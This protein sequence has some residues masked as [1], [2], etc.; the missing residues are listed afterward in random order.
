MSDKP[1]KKFKVWPEPSKIGQPYGPTPKQAELFIDELPIEKRPHLHP[2]DICL[3]IGGA[4]CLGKNTPV[5]MFD[6]SVKKVQDVKIGDLLIGPDSQPRKVEQLFRGFDNMYRIVPNKGESFVCNSSHILSLKTAGMTIKSKRIPGG[7]RKTYSTGDL[8]EISLEEY[9][10][11]SKTWKHCHKLWRTGVEFPPKKVSLDPY[12]LGLWLGDGG[13]TAP[14]V[15]NIDYEVINWLETFAK[16]QG[17][18]CTH[19][20]KSINHYIGTGARGRKNGKFPNN[21]ILNSLR[22]YDLINNKHI[23]EDYLRN[24]RTSRLLLLAGLIDSDGSVNSESGLRIAL[25]SE[26]LSNDVV[27]LARSLGFSTTIR[28]VRRERN[29]P[30]FQPIYQIFISGSVDEVPI[31]ISRKVPRE[32]T[33]VV[34]ACVTGF[35]VEDIGIGE[36]YGFELSGDRLFLLGDFTVT[37]NS[38]KTTASCARVISYLLKHPKST[39]IIGAMNFPILQRTMLKEFGERFGEV[40][41]WDMVGKPQSPILRKPTQTQKEVTLRNGSRALFIHFNDPLILRGISA[42]LIA[43][44]EASLLPDEESFEELCRRLSGNKGP[45]RQ[46][47]LTT[48]PTPRGGWI[49]D[50]FK[51]HQLAPNYEGVIEPI[52]P[53]CSCHKCQTCLNSKSGN[54]EFSDGVCPNCGNIKENECPGNQVYMRV[55]TTSAW[56][57]QHLPDDYVQT[58]KA[59]M[60]E[61]TYNIFIEGSI[62][63]I[64]DGFVYKGFGEENVYKDNEPIS[65]E[66][67]LI[68]TLD[69]NFEPQCSMICQ[70][71]ETSNGFCI[72]V[73]DEIVMWNALPEHAAEQFCAHP[74]VQAWKQAG[75]AVLIYGDP[76]GLF[77]TGDNLCASFYQIIY[78]VL[79]RN[80]FDAR[81]LMR[82]PE[83]G[84]YIKEPVKIPVAGRVDAVNSML[85]SQQDP[86]QIRLKINPQCLNLLKSFRELTWSDDGKNIDKLCDKRAKRSTDKDKDHLMTHPTDALGYYVYKRFP[87]VRN[88]TGI[89][90]FQ[91][92]G[93]SSITVIDGKIVETNRATRAGQLAE[94]RKKAREDRKEKRKDSLKNY[95]S[96]N[97]MWPGS[98]QSPFRTNWFF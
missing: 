43:Y 74:E 6:G 23:P 80:G 2:V 37:H 21:P 62:E 68:W 36:Y 93:Q 1:K 46:L 14:V 8:V 61:K 56:D 32:R 22:E 33:S 54:F 45:V 13:S 55:I 90:V 87:V 88:K 51:L 4:R 47:I 78:D 70:E 28:I 97:S 16:D 64:R 41:P 83:K 79:T 85:R 42:D 96:D 11:K 76:A 40:V 15:G 65:F 50:K 5:L 27:F 20:S 73:L 84:S 10:T 94:D 19:V 57:N 44:E 12:Y 66:K 9:L 67:D 48:N 7:R 31:K 38:G 82:K 52:C 69:F 92:P 17:L 53:P 98:N 26:I 30:N 29:N 60:D 75:R 86:P 72:K 59:F 63:N 18:V 35:S 71:E 49:N 58:Q 39:A 81:V 3:Y 89:T 77:G 95:L 34:D 24:D 25:T 91:V